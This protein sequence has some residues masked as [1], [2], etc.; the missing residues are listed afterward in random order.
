MNVTLDGNRWTLTLKVATNVMFADIDR[1]DL[2]VLIGQRLVAGAPLL[3]YGYLSGDGNFWFLTENEEMPWW[4]R[5]GVD[6]ML[7]YASPG[8][9]DA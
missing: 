1:N 5:F 6:Q 4:E 7:V 3:P 2:T 8:E 9:F